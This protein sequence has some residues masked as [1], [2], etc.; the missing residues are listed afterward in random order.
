[1]SVGAVLVLYGTARRP[2]SML[3]NLDDWISQGVLGSEED[4]LEKIKNKIKKLLMFFFFF[5]FLKK[6]EAN[7]GY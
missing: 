3:I 7:I 1:M 5:F 2:L 6:G 4:G